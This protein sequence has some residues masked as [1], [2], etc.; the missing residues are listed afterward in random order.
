MNDRTPLN[1]F[2][3]GNLP[4][5]PLFSGIGEN[6]C[7]KALRPKSLRFLQTLYQALEEFE[8]DLHQ[9]LPGEQYLI[10]AVGCD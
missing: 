2:G 4:E 5:A 10:P 1:A 6:K 8:K 3:L 7:N 9:Y